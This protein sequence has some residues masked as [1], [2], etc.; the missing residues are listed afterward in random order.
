MCVCACVNN[1]K[2]CVRLSYCG[3]SVAAA[4]GRIGQCAL[5]LSHFRKHQMVALHLANRYLQ[6]EMCQR[7]CNGHLLIW[8]VKATIRTFDCWLVTYL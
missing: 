7:C 3:S 1:G 5:E 2:L 4:V 8:V 6:V